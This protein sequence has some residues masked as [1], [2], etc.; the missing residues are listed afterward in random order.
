VVVKF[1]IR[2]AEL[3]RLS[4]ELRRFQPKLL[5]ALRAR[6]KQIGAAA[7]AAVDAKLDLPS[8]DSGNYPGDVRDELKQGT[9]TVVS[10]SRTQAG[11]RI[12]TRNTHLPPEHAGVLKSYNM[13]VFRH[14]LYGNRSVWVEQKG[15]PYFSAAIL[16]LQP[17]MQDRI[18]FAIDEAARSIGAHT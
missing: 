17:Q 5:S 6:M 18:Y 9:S 16:P 8:P 14:P 11:V 2:A 10:F 7:I 3:N 13:P 4:V 12:A 1:E 15:R